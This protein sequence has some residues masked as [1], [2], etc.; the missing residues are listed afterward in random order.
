MV[1]GTVNW[2]ELR[3]FRAVDLTRSFVLS[4]EFEADSLLIDLDLALCP[5]HTFYEE[6]RPSEMA[7]FRPA[8]LEFPNCTE[9]ISPVAGSASDNREV[10][11]DLE[12][13]K[14]GGFKLVAEG[15]YELSG[16]FGDV[17]I[18]AERPLLRLNGQLV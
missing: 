16:E 15:E 5:E 8:V 9:I 7:C 10:A 4:W 2:T 18:V 12:H 3:E 6:P 14:I 1:A 13:G 17:R 11:A